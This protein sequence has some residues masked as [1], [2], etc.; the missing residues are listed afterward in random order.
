MTVLFWIRKN[1]LNKHNEAAI[2]CRITVNGIRANDFSTNIFTNTKNWDSKKQKIK[3]D[4]VK[5]NQLTAIRQRIVALHI[6]FEMKGIPVTAEII[7]SIYTQ[8]EVPKQKLTIQQLFDEFFES[9]KRNAN[10]LSITVTFYKRR[11]KPLF[12]FISEKKS[13]ELT[14]TD[15]KPQFADELTEWLLNTKNYNPN[16]AQKVI[17]ISKMMF[18]YA[19]KRQYIV[20]NP[21]VFIKIKG[22]Q[23]PLIVLCKEELQKI[24]NHHFASPRLQEVADL[25]LLQCFTGM[26]YV[27]LIS[28]DKKT[29][30]QNGFI[31]INRQKSETESLIPLF[32]ETIALFEK[33]DYK[34]PQITNQKY[35]AYIKE[36][37][38]IVGIEKALTTH[39]GLKTC[40]SILLNEGVSIE[41]V[42]RILGH[43]DTKIT[44]HIYA[45]VNELRIK[46]EMACVNLKPEPKAVDPKLN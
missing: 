19:L 34:I 9:E 5:Q 15:I 27:D 46:R 23:K 7:K 40:G 29:H 13:R 36:V 41:V 1:K 21:F 22:R 33:Y 11:L 45:R 30:L 17:Q 24:M 37:A 31:S 25:F 14:I 2:Y 12:L 6:D 44:Q 35:N 38:E 10:R 32:P 42:S 39:V 18:N 26:A 4:D 20:A 8:K 28:F 16:Y 3:N 43:K